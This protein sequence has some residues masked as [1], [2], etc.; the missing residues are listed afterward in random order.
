MCLQVLRGN[1]WIA[2]KSFPARVGAKIPVTRQPHPRGSQGD[3]NFKKQS[4]RCLIRIKGHRVGCL[5]LCV[6]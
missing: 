4:D 2:F 1:L 6:D 5:R 3:N